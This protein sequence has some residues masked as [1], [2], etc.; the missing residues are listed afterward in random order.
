M[1]PLLEPGEEISHLFV[2][3]HG[4]ARPSKLAMM[5]IALTDRSV[6]SVPVKHVLRWKVSGMQVTRWPRVSFGD[7]PD[8]MV[9]FE[10]WSWNG[11]DLWLDRPG[12]NEA[13]AANVAL[14]APAPR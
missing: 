8:A 7:V 11:L 13:R 2:A 14:G 9:G 10:R 12:R 1:Q 4:I 5:A 6:V 3:N